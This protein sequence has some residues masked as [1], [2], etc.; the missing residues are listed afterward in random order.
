PRTED[1]TDLAL[2][3]FALQIARLDSLR[4]REEALI[5]GLIRETETLLAAHAQPRD[6]SR[7]L[8]AHAD[9]EVETPP[10]RD[11]IGLVRDQARQIATL[12]HQLA[13]LEATLAERK[14]IDKAKSLLMTHRQLS[15]E[16]AWQQLR[17]LAMNQNRRMVE[18]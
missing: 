13:S 10:G 3:W 6:F 2:R 1:P 15:E 5:A 4:Q 18:I 17:S 9:D 16:E 11:L 14:T 7:W 8:E 12:S